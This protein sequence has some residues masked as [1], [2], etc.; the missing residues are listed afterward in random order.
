MP[1]KSIPSLGSHDCVYVNAAS[2][3]LGLVY[4][5]VFFL[6]TLV[7]HCSENHIALFT[8]TVTLF[9]RKS[10]LSVC[11]C[12][13]FLIPSGKLMTLCMCLEDLEDL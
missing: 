5:K 12:K 9:I 8:M 2:N 4:I 3:L 7:S 1:Y 10:V 6:T 13:Y 11:R